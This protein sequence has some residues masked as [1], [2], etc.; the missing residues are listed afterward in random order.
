MQNLMTT[1]LFL[2][3][4]FPFIITSSSL[5]QTMRF[6]DDQMLRT[7]H[8]HKSFE[9]F[10]SIDSIPFG[11]INVHLIPHTHDDVGWLKTVDEYFYGSSNDIQNTQV[12]YVFDTVIV[13]LEK[14]PSKHFIYVEVAFFIRM[15]ER[16]NQREASF[17]QKTSCLWPIRVYQWWLVYE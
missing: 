17:S 8:H 15:V 1:K 13:E 6:G 12:Q 9:Q 5:N 4:L 10:T 2:L 14:D 3:C 16:T 7:H 11:T